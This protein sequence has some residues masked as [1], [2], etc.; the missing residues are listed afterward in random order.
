MLKK[1]NVYLVVVDVVYDAHFLGYEYS[2][3]RELVLQ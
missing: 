3:R 2:R 1:I